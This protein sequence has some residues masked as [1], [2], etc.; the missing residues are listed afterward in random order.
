MGK[1]KKPAPKVSAAPKKAPTTK[2]SIKQ[3]V[4]IPA[5]S[6]QLVHP[7]TVNPSPVEYSYLLNNLLMI[8]C[9]ELTLRLL[10]AIPSVPTGP[11]RSRAFLT[12][13]IVIVAE[14]DS[15]A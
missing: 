12:T 5:P 13:V 10:T 1:S 7:P 2:A 9:V 15:T 6:K 4:D 11:A 3:C 14:Y 8:A